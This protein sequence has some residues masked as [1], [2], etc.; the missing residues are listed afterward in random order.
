[1]YC[2]VCEKN[3]LNR[4]AT[5]GISIFPSYLTPGI[6]ALFLRGCFRQCHRL[7]LP[8]SILSSVICLLQIDVSH[9]FVVNPD[10]N[11]TIS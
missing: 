4:M 11:H 5:W 10:L 1:M 7:S 3:G 6:A 8:L 2:T 9:V